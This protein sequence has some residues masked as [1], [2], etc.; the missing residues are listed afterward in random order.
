L[1]L[2]PLQVVTL[3]S[4][5]DEETLKKS[6]KGNIA[7]TYLNRIKIGMPLQADPT[8]KYAMKDFA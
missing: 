6:D 8:V 4:I 3:A 1:H 5:V 2:T 7:S